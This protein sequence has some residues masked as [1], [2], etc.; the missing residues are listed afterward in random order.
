MILEHFLFS[1]AFAIIVGLL[2]ERSWKYVLP[3]WII[4]ACAVLPDFDY[5]I[6]TIMYPIVMVTPLASI[7]IVH[8]DSHNIAITI[9]TS[10]FCAWALNKYWNYVYNDVFICVFL[11][12]AFHII[13][14]FFVYV[15]VFCPIAPRFPCEIAGIGILRETGAW[16]GV[17]EPS[18][19]IVGSILLLITICIKI[20][21]SDNKWIEDKITEPEKT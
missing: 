15:T 19:I 6:Q 16:Y 8:G 17:A 4:F 11:G 5:I 10:M 18:I 1:A 20:Y 2:V 13:C 7:F 3:V 14:D 9:L 12:C 21:Y